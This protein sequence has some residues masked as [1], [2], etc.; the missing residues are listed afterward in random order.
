MNAFTSIKDIDIEIFSKVSDI[1]NLEKTCNYVKNIVSQ[2]SFWRKKLANDFPKRSKYIHYD[3]YLKLS[4]RDLY[5]VISKKSKI[6]SLTR[7]KFPNIFNNILDDYDI[8]DNIDLINCE[9]HKQLNNFPLIRGDIIHL[10]WFREYHNT[11]KVIWDGEKAVILS[12]ERDNFGHVPRE[13]TFPEFEL[14]HFHHTIDSKIIWLS[15]E[16]VKRA[17]RNFNHNC[18]YYNS[19]TLYSLLGD[20]VIFSDCDKEDFEDSI[21]NDPFIILGSK[22]YHFGSHF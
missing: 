16:S 11:G 18:D 6:V 13:F 14:D 2:D 15:S 17:V 9:I 3:K 5:K 12:Y 22:G 4:P 8:W 21:M 1:T 20:H 19:G 10:A 7:I